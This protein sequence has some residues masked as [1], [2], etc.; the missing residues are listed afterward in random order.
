MYFRT[1]KLVNILGVISIA[2]SF[3]A[4]QFKSQQQEAET[5]ATDGYGKSFVGKDNQHDTLSSLMN[6]KIPNLK[7][8][9]T[10]LG[11]IIAQNELTIIDFWASWCGPCRQEMP[12]MIKLYKNYHNK[13]IEI[14]GISLDKEYVDWKNAIDQLG[15]SWIQLSEL[16]GWEESLVQ[17]LNIRAIPHTL[18][19]DKQGNII[20]EG[21]RAEELQMLISKR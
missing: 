14:I 20:A 17:R 2:L 6:V 4:C 12:A 3:T 1:M 21:L 7:R 16:R 11:D 15:M 18:L 8:E 13:G 5:A 9:K 10:R 19:L